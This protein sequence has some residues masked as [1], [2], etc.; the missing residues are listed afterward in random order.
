LHG[1]A[2]RLHRYEQENQNLVKPSLNFIH[3]S[4]AR[5]AHKGNPRGSGHSGSGPTR[6]CGKF[7]NFQCQICLKFG[8]IANAC[9]F[10][11]DE[12]YHPPESLFFIDLAT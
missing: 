1:H 12:S 4:Y 3:G 2:T 6:G 8:D 7:A 10:R 11:S 9:H 5:S